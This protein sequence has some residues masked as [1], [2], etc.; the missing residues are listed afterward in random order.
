MLEINVS[1]DGIPSMVFE[2]SRTV[3][4]DPAAFRFLGYGHHTG[5]D[6][7]LYVEQASPGEFLHNASC[8]IADD[9][10]G[11]SD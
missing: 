7:G 5:Q 4:G 3:D 9:V 8:V 2:A 1:R 10:T 6:G 11:Q